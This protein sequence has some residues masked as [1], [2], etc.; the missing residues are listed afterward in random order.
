LQ[1]HPKEIWYKEK[2]KSRGLIS[3]NAL[4]GLFSGDKAFLTAICFLLEAGNFSG[5]HRI[6]PGA[7]WHFYAGDPLTGIGDFPRG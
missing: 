2:Y 4:P 6:K 1:P 5:F 7:C 3:S